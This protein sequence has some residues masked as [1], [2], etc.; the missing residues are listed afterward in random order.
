MLAK[1]SGKG[2]H[3]ESEL[4][5]QLPKSSQSPQIT[6]Y[7]SQI[8]STHPSHPPTTNLVHIPLVSAYGLID[9]RS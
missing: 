9:C 8:P 3:K 5:S 7:P 6:A 1:F 4:P 2:H